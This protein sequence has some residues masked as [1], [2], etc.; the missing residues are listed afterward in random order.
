MINQA[1]LF[2]YPWDFVDEGP[3][4]VIAAVQALGVT[5]VIVASLYHAGFLLY[6]HN[7]RRS[8][9]MLEDGVAYFHPELT[10]YRDGPMHPRIASMCQDQDWFRSICDRSV[11]AG[12]K[13]G[14]WAVVCH[15]TPLGLEHPG[16]TIQNAFGDSYP[17][18]LSPG[19]PDTVAY[20]RG[21]VRDLSHRYPLDFILL[22]AVD[23]RRRRHGADWVAGHHH[24][25][26]GTFLRPLESALLDVSFN[27][28]DVRRGKAAGIDVESLREAVASHL[29]RYFDAAPAMPSDLPA[30]IKAFVERH[31]D[32][33]A[34]RAAL[35]GAATEFSTGLRDEAHSRGVRLMGSATEAVDIAM[36]SAYGRQPVEVEAI[37]RRARAESRP[38][39]QVAVLIRMGFNEPG[40][41]TP[42][43]SEE[44]MV[45][46]TRAAVDGGADLVGYY[47][48]GEAPIRSVR[49]IRPALDA[50]GLVAPA[51]A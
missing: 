51:G 23:Y 8:T 12:L 28:M 48:Y 45:D 15:N 14:A 6:P 29:R 33:V 2:I 47:N 4:K 18:A 11:A 35:A 21:L 40:L 44:Q 22:E 16:A 5:H 34:Y 26:D 27:P 46:V 42:I 36:V 49:W 50:V 19:H 43:T 38:G 20:G 9:H 24:E 3:D 13:V 17:H 37:A 30:T 41:G 32:F 7:P 39:Q 25:R 31:A 1:G 10:H